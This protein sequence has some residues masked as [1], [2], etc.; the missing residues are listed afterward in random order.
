M[1]KFTI[2]LIILIV[3]GIAIGMYISYKMI[4]AQRALASA[5]S[6]LEGAW[7][8]S[9]GLIGYLDRLYPTHLVFL[10]HSVGNGIMYTGGLRDSLLNL[11]V[12]ARSCTYGDE[13]GQNTDMNHWLNK[14][15]NDMPRIFSFRAHPDKYYDDGTANDIIMFKSCFPNSNIIG[16]GTAPGD[17]NSPEKTITNY[18]AVFEG[19][20]TEFAKYPKKLFVYVTAPPNVP[21]ATTPENAARARTFNTWLVEEYLPAY[22]S[23]T[24]LDNFYI[25][26]LF[27]FLTGPDNMLK[28]E[29]RGSHPQDSHPNTAGKKAAAKAFIEFFKPVLE[30]YKQRTE[31]PAK[32]S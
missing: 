29:Y 6:H 5:Q 18:K 20:K 4:K 15:K 1:N 12:V 24:G 30:A 23:E 7:F 17:P 10:H 9:E 25:Y 16:E 31:A 27:G 11:G 8:V 22:K 14:F 28:P 32:T 21:G 2:V 26:D 3:L 13:I 19:L